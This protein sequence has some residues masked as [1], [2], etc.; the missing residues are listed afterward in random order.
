MEFLDSEEEFSS[1]IRLD[2]AEMF[3]FCLLQ[4]NYEKN[5]ERSISK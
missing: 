4:L 2:I 5:S 3:A 1:I